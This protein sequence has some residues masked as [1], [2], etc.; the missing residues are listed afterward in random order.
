MQPVKPNEEATM[1]EGEER[2]GG[3]ERRDA[4]QRKLQFLPV[5]RLDSIL[6]ALG[7][8]G[9]GVYAYG[10]FRA[11]IAMIKH[12]QAVQA[13]QNQ[14]MRGEI[15]EVKQEVRQQGEVIE[16]GC[17]SPRRAR[18]GHPAD[19]SRLRDA[20]KRR[21]LSPSQGE[22]RRR[23]PRRAVRLPVSAFEYVRGVVIPAALSMLP[24]KMDTPPARAM[25][26][27]IGLQESGFKHRRQVGGG[28]AI[29]LW[30]GEP[31]GGMQL[32]DDHAATRDLML[33]VLERMGYDEPGLGSFLA[34]EHNDILACIRA[35][36]LLFTHPAPLP[37]E[38]AEGWRQYLIVWGPG[39]PRRHTWDAFYERAWEAV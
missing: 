25:L 9:A 24:P 22:A 30:Q 29:S 16:R 11:D 6:T 3:D 8:L 28:P 34:S 35:R 4:Q 31:G 18:Y 39:R 12:S 1:A 14:H 36:L 27:A 19:A 7:V 32:V 33:D 21:V 17:D 38:A 23:Q 10:D 20:G 26:L 5:I 37:R 15:R 13:E 2:W